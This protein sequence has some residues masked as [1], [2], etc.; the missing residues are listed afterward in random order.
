MYPGGAG[1]DAIHDGM[2]VQLTYVNSV[3]AVCLR[4]S[5]PAVRRAQ[6]GG[7]REASALAAIDS[8]DFD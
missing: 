7:G 1:A 3:K 8:S 5:C 4:A 6:P 2:G